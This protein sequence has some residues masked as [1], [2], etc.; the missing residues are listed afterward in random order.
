MDFRFD[1]TID[2]RPFTALSMTDDVASIV[3][4]PPR[5]ALACV[6]THEAAYPPLELFLAPSHELM[7]TP[8]METDNWRRGD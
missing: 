5:L 8:V 1:S 7:L 4:I 3:G 6:L 2:G